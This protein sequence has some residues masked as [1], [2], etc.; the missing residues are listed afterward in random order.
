M[1][2]YV[3]LSREN[4]TYDCHYVTK[5]NQP[6]EFQCGHTVT[7]SITTII[8]F[9]NSDELNR[10]NTNI[11]KGNCPRCEKIEEFRLQQEKY[12]AEKG[13]CY[14]EIEWNHQIF[15]DDALMV[16]AH[17]S[18]ELWRSIDNEK[19]P[20]IYKEVAELINEINEH[21]KKIEGMNSNFE[22]SRNNFGMK[23]CFDTLNDHFFRA[24]RYLARV[25]SKL[26]FII[27]A[28]YED[29]SHLSD[30]GRNFIH[31]KAN[32][33]LASIEAEYKRREIYKEYQKEL[34]ERVIYFTQD[35]IDK[36]N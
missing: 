8:D 36:T 10:W 18:Y 19:Y 13:D 33:I 20:H 14:N 6:F 5:E 1:R 16:I 31:H 26:I 2:S 22:F 25:H 35:D 32:L 30:V 23:H 21:E 15:V 4:H 29:P 9:N 24:Q 11:A 7:T 12:Q 28:I 34:S 17:R 3:M 27:R